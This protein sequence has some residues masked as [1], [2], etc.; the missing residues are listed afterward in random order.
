MCRPHPCHS[1][2]RARNSMGNCHSAEARGEEPMYLGPIC[3]CHL[4]V[5]RRS[6]AD[7]KPAIPSYA[8]NTQS[9]TPG[10]SPYVL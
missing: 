5:T 7:P 1:E 3:N 9:E 8:P 4:R 2:S 10:I 6:Q